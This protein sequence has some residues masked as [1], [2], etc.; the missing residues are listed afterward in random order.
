MRIA[1]LGGGGHGVSVA[2]HLA[3]KGVKDISIIEMK[4]INYGSSGRNAGRYRYHF[5]SKENVDF[6]KHAIPYLLELCKKLPLNPV[7]YRTG[8]LWILKNDE[9]FNF[10]RRMD[11][12]W[13]SFGVGGKF[14][15]C[16]EMDYLKSQDQCY[17]APQDGSFH[18]D[19]L[20]FGLYEEIKEK[21]KI[22]NGE[23]REILTSGGKVVG[24]RVNEVTFPADQVV[25]T[26]GAW[27]GD[28]LGKNGFKV[29]IEPEKKEIF[30]TEDLKFRVKPLV[31]SD[32]IYF[33]HTLKGEIIGGIEDS[34]PR[35]FTNFD[36]SLERTLIFL[37]ELRKLVK[38]AEGIRILRGWSG[39]YE[40]TPDHSHIMGYSQMWPEGLYI[41]A[42]Y[43]G[44]GMMF[45][46]FSGKIMA[47]LI[48][49]GYK[50]KFL[51]VFN[52]DRFERNKLVDERMVI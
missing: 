27:A 31:I 33:S 3:K 44:H 17:L 8:Y 20:T 30:I 47:D 29:P 1:I 36:V 52:P 51:D 45:A 39:Y 11:T 15:D 4:R 37:K 9:T 10:I 32:Q 24:V 49:D 13:E 19:Y 7:C 18:H 25:V 28:F 12:L 23:A 48:A 2:Y 50:N 35:M 46:P 26:L 38:G 34:S 6:A 22:I 41:D 16:S 5:H 43:S 40:M 14:L 42:G 21:V